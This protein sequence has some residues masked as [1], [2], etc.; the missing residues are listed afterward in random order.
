MASMLTVDE[1][2]LLLTD[3]DSSF[4]L[5]VEGQMIHQVTLISIFQAII[6]R[7]P[8]HQMF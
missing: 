3:H 5:Y 6:E 1:R 2:K 8:F 4:I 7:S